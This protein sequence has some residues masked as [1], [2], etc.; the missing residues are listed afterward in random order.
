M[1]GWTGTSAAGWLG[2]RQQKGLAK[3]RWSVGDKSALASLQGWGGQVSERPSL[4]L[5]FEASRHPLLLPPPTPT[6]SRA[7]TRPSIPAALPPAP[8]P[9]ALSRTR[10]WSGWWGGGGRK[11]SCS[12]AAKLFI[13]RENCF[14]KGKRLCSS[15]PPPNFPYRPPPAPPGLTQLCFGVPYPELYSSLC[16]VSLVSSDPCR[17]AVSPRVP[18]PSVHLSPHLSQQP[19]LA[20]AKGRG[21]RKGGAC[22]A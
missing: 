21:L 9:P 22:Q 18:Q 14:H 1:V 12:P 7:S 10:P 17:K 19:A 2:V 13:F 16:P 15:L 4:S 20:W 3:L 6:T 11:F 8:P 5:L